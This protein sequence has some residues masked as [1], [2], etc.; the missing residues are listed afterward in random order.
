MS[1]AILNWIHLHDPAFHI[2]NH[3]VFQPAARDALISLAASA[4]P[5]PLAPSQSGVTGER[6]RE[7]LVVDQRAKEVLMKTQN[8]ADPD[9]VNLFMQ[10]LP[11]AATTLSEMARIAANYQPQTLDNDGANAA[12]YEDYLRRMGTNPLFTLRMADVLTYNRESS[13]WNQVIDAIA[14]TF[15]GVAAKD[16]NTIVKGLK[17]LAQ[18]ASSKMSTTQ[19]ESLFVQNAVNIDG[20]VS[21]YLY[22][23]KVT[24]FET[25]E[26]GYDT[27][28]TTYDIRRV[29]FELQSKLWPEYAAKVAQKYTA[30]VDDWLNN[31]ST[32]T[33]GTSPIPA[34]N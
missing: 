31:N 7:G 26:K 8:P 9:F 23:S 5:S 25:N 4:P 30:F 1:D 6:M 19:T 16:K 34:L 17:T 11:G 2:G 33:A 27:K 20:V 24:F 22:S 10:D 14:D 32:S 13:D 28:Q 15:E 12:A 18:A 3:G 21:L 29:E